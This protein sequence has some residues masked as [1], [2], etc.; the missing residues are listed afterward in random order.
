[1][2]NVA[3]PPILD[4]EPA[5]ITVYSFTGSVIIPTEQ[6]TYFAS[7]VGGV[8]ESR[9]TGNPFILYGL[10]YIWDM[11]G[12]VSEFP[13]SIRI[14]LNI[15]QAVTEVF[16][17]KFPAFEPEVPADGTAAEE[18]LIENDEPVEDI[19]DEEL[20]DEGGGEGDLEEAPVASEDELSW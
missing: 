5:P 17:F 13:E 3:K 1:M 4:D 8:V 9:P 7:A 11:A 14:R 12:Q 6:G 19:D 18:V 20:L 16:D 10:K 15:A 2:A